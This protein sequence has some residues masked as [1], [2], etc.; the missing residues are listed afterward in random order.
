RSSRTIKA[1]SPLSEAENP[2]NCHLAHTS[3]AARRSASR[4]PGRLDLLGT[5]AVGAEDGVARWVFRFVGRRG[6]VGVHVFPDRIA[7]RCHLE[8]AAEG[9]FADEGVAVRQALGVGKVRCE[10]IDLLPL[11]I[12]PDD[13]AGAW[14]DLQHSRKGHEMI[15]TARAVVE[16]EDIAV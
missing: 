9:A 4:P 8:E 6:E 15:R 7:A 3:S 10:E 13:L 5:E 1:R 11:L 12:G 16:D 2:N 14:V